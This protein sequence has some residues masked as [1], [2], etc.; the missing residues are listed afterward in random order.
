MGY[1]VEAVL[2]KSLSELLVVGKQI[3]EGIGKAFMMVWL[4]VG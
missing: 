1:A 4:V 2:I 3:I